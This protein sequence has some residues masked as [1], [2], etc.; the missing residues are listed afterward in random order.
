MVKT[1]VL[2]HVRLNLN[3]KDLLYDKNI[4][5]MKS[6]FFFENCLNSDYSFFLNKIE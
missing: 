3:K 5:K 2:I 6:D 1:Q 4:Q